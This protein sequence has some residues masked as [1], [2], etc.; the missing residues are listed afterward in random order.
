LTE[1]VQTLTLIS[2][3]S[4]LK[5]ALHQKAPFSSI[6]EE[7]FLSLQLT[8]R[9]VL[10]PWAKFLKAAVNFTP[11]QYN[12]LRILRGAAPHGRTCGEIS[13]RLVTRDPDVTRIVDRLEKRGLVRRERSTTDRRVVRVFITKDGQSSLKRLDQ[14]VREMPRDLLG[15]MGAKRLGSLRDL[16][17][18]V[19]AEL[20]RFPSQDAESPKTSGSRR[21]T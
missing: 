14:A 1:V 10:D 12:L 21:S 15:P 11:V 9:M 3:S 2:V 4:E 8:A 16:L 13:E 7:V 5:S 19:R 18:S 17:A 6:E 20:G